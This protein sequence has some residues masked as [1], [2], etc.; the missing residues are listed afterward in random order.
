MAHAFG[1]YKTCRY[2]DS[3]HVTRRAC[4]LGFFSLSEDHTPFRVLARSICAAAGVLV[5]CSPVPFLPFPYFLSLPFPSL[6]FASR[7]TPGLPLHSPTMAQ[8][9][10]TPGDPDDQPKP[11][12][13]ST[14]ESPN[15]KQPTSHISSPAPTTSSSSHPQKNPRSPQPQIQEADQ[16]ETSPRR[17][18]SLPSN[19]ASTDA[20]G[21]PAENDVGSQPMTKTA[22]SG[23]NSNSKDA[24]S[25]PSPYGTRS[26]NRGQAR[27]NYAE[28][29]DHDIEMEDAPA[30]KKEPEPRKLSRQV[31]GAADAQ[32]S[33]GSLRKA[34]GADDKASNASTP[35]ATTATKD[36]Q[37]A[38]SSTVNGA[39][40]GTSTATS[41]PKK[42]KALATTAG[43]TTSNQSATP[44]PSAPAPVS[45]RRAAAQA[46][47]PNGGASGYKETNMMSFEKCGGMPKDGEMIA[48]DG[49][50]LKVN[51]KATMRFSIAGHAFSPPSPSRV[52]LAGWNFWVCRLT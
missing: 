39:G 11:A 16:E 4:G 17:R 3:V 21:S 8:K 30:E 33:A 13:S 34:S 36:A 6:A 38:A 32:R 14:K 41:N 22:S 2:D 48:D 51:G 9:T 10:Q 26:R 43:N 27:P 45:T 7:V 46:S 20:L 42:R 19:K 37:A 24:M 47:T 5:G 18:R 44:T 23:S 35:A 25:G 1:A 12:S 40:N 52:G 49:T 50:V 28:D 29:K 15:Q 31:N